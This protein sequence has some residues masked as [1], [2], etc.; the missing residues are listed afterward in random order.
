VLHVHVRHSSDQRDRRQFGDLR[1]TVIGSVTDAKLRHR[2]DQRVWPEHGFV[3]QLIDQGHGALQAGTQTETG[4][5]HTKLRQSNVSGQNFARIGQAIQQQIQGKMTDQEG[6]QGVDVCQGGGKA[7]TEPSGPLLDDPCGPPIDNTGS[8]F[9]R[10]GQALTQQATAQPGGSTN[11]NQIQQGTASG[12]TATIKQNSTSGRNESILRQ[13][14]SSLAQVGSGRD[15]EDDGHSSLAQLSSAAVIPGS[16]TQA[17]GN[18]KSGLHGTINQVSTGI[19]TSDTRQDESQTLRAPMGATQSQFGPEFC[20]STQ[21]S[22]PNDTDKIVQRTVQT[23]NMGATQRDTIE[24]D[25]NTTGNCTISQQATQN[26]TMTS[27]S[28][29]GNICTATIT[30][31]SEGAGCFRSSSSGG[32]TMIAPVWT[33]D[34]RADL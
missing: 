21:A 28:C 17:Q 24:G 34:R 29:S 19:S 5:Q 25:C 11:I 18:F 23:A 9:V 4:E 3:E 31:G 12:A 14:H 2:T 1:A 20:C 22:N 27:N 7:Y 13:P 8:N 30:C 15:E 6:T 32:L 33:V 26:G 16:T 10:V